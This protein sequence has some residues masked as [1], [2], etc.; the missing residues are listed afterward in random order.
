MIEKRLN[1]GELHI[2]QLYSVCGER[3]YIKP[4]IEKERARAH[5]VIAQA[6][7]SDSH[8]SRQTHSNRLQ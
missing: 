3:Q 4:G 1:N 2:L 5:N 6:G 8:V 7:T